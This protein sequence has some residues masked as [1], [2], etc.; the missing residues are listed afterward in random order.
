MS[1]SAQEVE[2]WQAPFFETPV[3]RAKQMAPAEIEALAQSRGF[4]AGKWEGLESGRVEAEQIVH[5][6]TELLDEIAKPYRSLDHLVTQELANL[7]ML[8][9]KQVI[10]REL[11]INSD[12]VT[13]MAKE[14]LSTISSMEGEIEISLHPSDM[15]M[16]HQLAKGSLEGKSWKLAI[17]PE[18]LPGGCR[19]KTPLSYVDGSIEKQMEMAFSSLMDVCENGLEE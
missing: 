10:R 18:F 11:M 15:E 7:A 13:D 2:R 8:I 5:R 3:T 9:A 16:V 1:D 14:A 19:V 6:M 17:D 12:V 4:Q